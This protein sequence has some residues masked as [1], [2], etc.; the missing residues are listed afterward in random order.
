MLP[1]LLFLDC[2][3]CFFLLGWRDVLIFV[4]NVME[5][6]IALLYLN[7]PVRVYV[8]HMSTLQKPS[9]SENAILS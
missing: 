3:L 9:C 5:I 4:D 8:K 2:V 7:I 6:R 1:V